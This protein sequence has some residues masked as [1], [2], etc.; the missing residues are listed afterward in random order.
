MK[1]YKILFFGWITAVLLVGFAPMAFCAEATF[2]W[3]PNSETNL[4]GYKIHYGT[5]PGVYDSEFDVG[6]PATNSDGRVYGTV[7]GLPTGETLYFAA[8]AYDDDGVGSD[9]STE[10]M[11]RIKLSAPKDFTGSGSSVVVTTT[12]Q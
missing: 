3:L 7:Q 6:L 1:N 10:V 8:T 9:F 5:A 12:I 4:A 11:V 2:S